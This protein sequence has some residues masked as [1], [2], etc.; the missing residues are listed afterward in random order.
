[1]LDPLP[2]ACVVAPGYSGISLTALLAEP[3]V[4]LDE[5]DDDDLPP[6]QP[7]IASATASA[8]RGILKKRI[9]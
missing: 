9:P 1:M 8:R 7:V 6:P 3:E 2:A 5:S 4:V